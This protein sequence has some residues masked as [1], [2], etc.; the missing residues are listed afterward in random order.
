MIQRHSTT[1]LPELVPHLKDWGANSADA[2]IMQTGNLEC[3]IGYLDLAWR[4][5]VLHDG[6]L[7]PAGFNIENYE[8]WMRATKQDRTAVEAVMNHLHILDLFP[9]Q[10]EEPTLAQ[11]LVIGRVLREMWTAKLS[12]EHPS[13][14]VTVSFP[15]DQIFDD[16][17]DYEI[18]VFVSRP[19]T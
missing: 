14:P 18:T 17:L 16:L 10:R 5:F 9:S 6:C 4:D 12:R 8:E 2:W 19:K 3:L 1:P 15:D 13:L 7:L 11:V